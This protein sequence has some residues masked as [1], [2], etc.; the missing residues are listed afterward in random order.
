MRTI[1]FRGKRLDNDEWVYGFLY[2]LELLPC[3][4]LG[5]MILTDDDN[6]ESDAISPF[7]L[8]FRKG[9]D[10]FMVDPD[11]V[12]QFTGL[13]DAECVDI[14]EGD[15]LLSQEC[16][17]V[18]EVIYDAP[19]FVLNDNDLGYRFL[20]HPGNFMVI[21]TTHDIEKGGQV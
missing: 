5:T 12:G 17:E 1:K 21:G 11:T 8:A 2:Q 16:G 6:C 7:N 10:L 19:H 13:Q 15:L 18:F 20:N 14:Y 3:G 4:G 9:V